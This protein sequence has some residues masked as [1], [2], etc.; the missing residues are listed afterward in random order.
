MQFNN[1]D[2]Y[3]N[4]IAVAHF[5]T[6]NST[7]TQSPASFSSGNGLFSKLTQLEF[8]DRDRLARTQLP[9]L[10]FYSLC[11]YRCLQGVQVVRSWDSFTYLTLRSPNDP[12][13]LGI[14]PM[15]SHQ[16][17]ARSRL[18]SWT[19]S[20]ESHSRE[21]AIFDVHNYMKGIELPHFAWCTKLP[22][23]FY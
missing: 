13:V 16:W 20:S 11:T 3:N 18:L 21:V 6:I 19:Y 10:S 4:K 17:W 14:L 22:C 2:R 12:N 7:L 5:L 8:K 1:I 9:T 15:H 23:Y